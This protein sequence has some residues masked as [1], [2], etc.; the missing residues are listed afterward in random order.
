MAATRTID[1]I[2]IARAP[3][4]CAMRTLV[5]VSILASCGGPAAAPSPTTPAAATPP[6]SNDP[7]TNESAPIEPFRIVG[8][9]YYIGAAN[10]SSFLFA[11]P[12]GL[13]VGRSRLPA[14]VPLGG[15]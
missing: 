8:N 7:A 10:I 5:L 2:A 3:S 15:G 6:P 9:L 1:W 4:V 11:T 14:R 12:A 13:I